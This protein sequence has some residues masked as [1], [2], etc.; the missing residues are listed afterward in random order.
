MENMADKVMLFEREFSI[1]ENLRLKTGIFNLE[2]MFGRGMGYQFKLL[3]MALADVLGQIRD[4][5]VRV[6]I[7]KG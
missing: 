6:V 2:R 7:I 1:S 5:V 4:E 3:D